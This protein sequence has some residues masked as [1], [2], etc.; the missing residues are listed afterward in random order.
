M[1]VFCSKRILH[2]FHWSDVAGGNGGFVAQCDARGHQRLTTSRAHTLG[3]TWVPTVLLH[4]FK[5]STQ[6]TLHRALHHN[7]GAAPR[8]GELIGIPGLL[9]GGHTLS[10]QQLLLSSAASPSTAERCILFPLKKESWNGISLSSRYL[11]F[12]KIASSSFDRAALTT[13]FEI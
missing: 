8:G 7:R 6:A 5:F 2:S 1:E 12:V 10:V 11:S 13:A 4:V 9:F 3:P